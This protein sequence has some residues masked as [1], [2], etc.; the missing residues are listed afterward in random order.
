MSHKIIVFCFFLLFAVKSNAQWNKYYTNTTKDLFDI[1]IT[2]KYGFICGQNS[3]LLKSSDSGKSWSFLNLTTPSN[4]RTLYFIDSLTGFVCGE[5]ARVQKTTNGGSSFTQKFV[6][7]SSYIYDMEFKDSNG[8]AV[9]KDMLIISSKNNGES[10]SVDTTILD[11]R[12]INSLAI[13]TNGQC[14]AVG[15]SGYFLTKHITRKKWNINRLLTIVNLNHVSILNDSI[16]FIAGGMADTG[17]V[18]KYYNVLFQSRDTGKSWVQTP[19]NE[20]KIINSAF[21]INDSLGTLVG[22]NG[23]VSKC[24]GGINNRGQQL[25]KTSSTLHKI[26]YH[27]NQGY[28]VGDGG[29]LLMSNN[30]GGYGL[31]TSSN[32][33]Q[34]T[35]VFPNPFYNSFKVINNNENSILLAYSLDGKLLF[36][37]D[38][39][40]GENTVELDTKGL[41]F[42]RILTN[43]KLIDS[44]IMLSN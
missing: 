21:F 17:T 18:G 28:I 9:G 5:N 27:N 25:T 8:I 24:A 19:I 34:Q 43:D 36:Q 23:I 2:G 1:Q 4:L 29:L 41:V 42:L 12:A 37:K 38:L 6:R 26:I 33:L 7:T 30:Y 15:D 11:K 14:Y 13:A 20:M 35:M 40:M 44:I 22:S 3:A 10:W 39:I 31:N 32:V 16:V